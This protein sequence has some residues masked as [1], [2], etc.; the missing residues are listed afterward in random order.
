MSGLVQFDKATQHYMLD[1][2]VVEIALAVQLGQVLREVA[3]PIL[4]QETS[5]TPTA[6]VLWVSHEG[7]VLCLDHIRPPMLQINATSFAV[8]ALAPLNCGGGPR[9]VVAFVSDEER[10]L[11]LSGE[12]PRRRHSVIRQRPSCERPQASSSRRDGS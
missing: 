1:A 9:I 6:A 8:H 11:G 12:S 10:E 3:P 2:S 5:K 7:S 4:T